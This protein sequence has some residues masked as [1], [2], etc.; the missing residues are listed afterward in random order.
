MFVCCHLWTRKS[1]AG[2][3]LVFFFIL[4]INADKTVGFKCR[5]LT[6]TNISGTMSTLT[7]GPIFFLLRR[8]G[9]R[10]KASAFTTKEVYRGKRYPI[11]ICF[12]RTVL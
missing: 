8:A 1:L 5:G 3:Y 7:Q 11:G 4:G 12:L 9:S 10:K 6:T 2:V